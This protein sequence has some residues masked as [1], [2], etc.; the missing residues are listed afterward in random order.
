[1]LKF[2]RAFINDGFR[3][4]IAKEGPKWTQ[5]VIHDGGSIRVK[6]VKGRLDYSPL[7]GKKGK[8]YT[9]A[10]FATLFLRSGRKNKYGIKFHI[11][12]S[13]RALLREAQSC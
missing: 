2:G 1:M 12:K 3:P 10:Q 11:T 5:A 6:R 13:A 8:D 7:Y 9:L 4:V